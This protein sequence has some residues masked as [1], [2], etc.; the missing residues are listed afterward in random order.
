M[1]IIS[2]LE[3]WDTFCWNGKG[4]LVLPT[5]KVN[6]GQFEIIK[7]KLHYDLNYDSKNKKGKISENTVTRFKKWMVLVKEIKKP[8]KGIFVSIF[9]EDNK[10]NKSDKNISKIFFG[11]GIKINIDKKI[12]NNDNKRLKLETVYRMVGWLKDSNYILYPDN[13]IFSPNSLIAYPQDKKSII[14]E[15]INEGYSKE[16]VI[17]NIGYKISKNKYNK[18]S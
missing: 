13:T 12:N 6:I 8:Q 7:G 17:R 14:K 9:N 15:K 1:I 10:D 18:Y 2:E 5:F 3:E 4:E 11:M 16:S